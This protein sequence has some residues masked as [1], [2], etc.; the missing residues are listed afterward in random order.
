MITV[1]MK[2][3]RVVLVTDF[4][5]EYMSIIGELLTG[6]FG[7]WDLEKDTNDVQKFLNYF[8]VM[9]FGIYSN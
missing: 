5:W 9:Y 8:S 3:Q 1:I 7:P 4:E 2:M 6:R